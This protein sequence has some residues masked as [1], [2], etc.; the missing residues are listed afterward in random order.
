MGST[1]RDIPSVSFENQVL[2]TPYKLDSDLK[3]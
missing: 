3:I 2:V 1:A